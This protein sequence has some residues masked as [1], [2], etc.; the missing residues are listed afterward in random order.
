[1]NSK[2]HHPDL[3]NYDAPAKAQID[4][5]RPC[6]DSFATLATRFDLRSGH[7]AKHATALLLD[8][9]SRHELGLSVRQIVA[10]STPDQRTM[11]AMVT[12]PSPARKRA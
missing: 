2:R 8:R 12:S 4:I 6:S 1:M 7:E 5:T 11:V 9:F 3:H 10:V